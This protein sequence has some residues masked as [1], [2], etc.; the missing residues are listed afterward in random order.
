MLY[1][2]DQ[3][4]STFYHHAMI[5]NSYIQGAYRFVNGSQQVADALIDVIHRQGGTVRCNAEVTLLF[6]D[7]KRISRVEINGEETLSARYVISS[8][9]PAAL[10]SL[11]EKNSLIRKAYISRMRSL[12][13]SYG[14]FSVYLVQKPGVTPY[15]NHNIYIHTEDNVWH[16]SLHPDDTCIKTCMVSMQSSAGSPEHTDVIYLLSPM[17]FAEI[18]R[19]S[20]TYIERRGEEYRAFK[21]RKAEELINLVERYYPGLTKNT[22]AVYTATPLSYRDYTG[23][24]EGSAYGII[25]DY[26]NP[27]TT[28]VSTRTRFSNLFQTGQNLNVHGALGVTLSSMLTCSEL[29]GK[30]YLA[31]KVAHV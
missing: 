21:A 28:L 9:H 13:N 2:G 31:N 20:D 18:S 5:N 26:R 27:L 11:V 22:Q 30:T 6:V 4:V 3:Q 16:A 15:L 10:N 8:L 1:A 24:P 14:F 12:P 23:T 17:Y 29:L 25:K 7:E 19:W